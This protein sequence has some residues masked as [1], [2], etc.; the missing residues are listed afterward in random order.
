MADQLQPLFLSVKQ[1]AV[2]ENT[3]PSEIY[4]R[5]A[6]GEYVAVKDGART[7]IRYDSILRRAES[8]PKA[9]IKLYQRRRRATPPQP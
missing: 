8:L 5:I 6:R 3:C 9:E 2:I 7:K 4:Q 1:T